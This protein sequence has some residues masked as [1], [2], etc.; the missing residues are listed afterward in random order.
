MSIL[1]SRLSSNLLSSVLY[2]VPSYIP[3]KGLFLAFVSEKVDF[4]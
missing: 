1:P 4:M 2:H 3:S